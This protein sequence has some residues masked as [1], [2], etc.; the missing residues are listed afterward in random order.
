MISQFPS[1]MNAIEDTILKIQH[2]ILVLTSMLIVLN[3]QII[4]NVLLVKE[5]KFHKINLDHV[6]LKLKIALWSIQQMSLNVSSV[7]RSSS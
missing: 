3:A 6:E 2:A 7:K 4:R 5:I 1:V